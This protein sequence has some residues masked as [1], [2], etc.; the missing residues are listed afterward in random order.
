MGTQEHEGPNFSSSALYD[1]ANSH[2]KHAN[3]DARVNLTSF[4]IFN[5]HNM[6][7]NKS[8]GMLGSSFVGIPKCENFDRD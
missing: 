6:H 5:S 1:L 7:L 8:G 3:E 2:G 4:N